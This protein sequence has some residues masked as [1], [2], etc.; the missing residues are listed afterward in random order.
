MSEVSLDSLSL[1]FA[2]TGTVETV[3]VS[4]GLRRRQVADIILPTGRVGIGLPGDLVN[5]PSKVVPEVSP[6]RY[7]VFISAATHTPRS[8]FAFLSILFDPVPP[9]NWQPVGG[10]FTDSGDG[11]IYDISLAEV[12]LQ[13]K[14]EMDLNQWHR[15]KIATTHEDGDGS[16]LLDPQTGANAIVFDTHDFFYPAFIGYDAA[17]KTVCL[18]I[19]GRLQ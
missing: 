5:M 4:G 6:G 3:G 18:V 16:L 19:D 10:F 8:S 7:P 14:R 17:G 9:S 2:N 11:A 13:V 12:V 15:L 1:A